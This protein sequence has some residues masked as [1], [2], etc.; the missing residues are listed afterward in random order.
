L[1]ALAISACSSADHHSTQGEA[2]S[3]E[4][5]RDSFPVD[6]GGLAPTGANSYLAIQP[7]RVLKLAHGKDHL[8][9]SILPGTKTVDG[10]ATGVL[11]ER[12]EQN[13]QLIE[14]SR[15]YFATDPNTGDVYYFGE[16]VD[17]YKD[18]QLVNH[19]SAWLAGEKGAR[20]GLM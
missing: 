11:E 2:K 7:G 16:E 4:G 10:V 8:T 6:K 13:G 17:N 19:D 12:E 3:N 20:F 18:G 14:I 15:N 1:I 9:V 5:W